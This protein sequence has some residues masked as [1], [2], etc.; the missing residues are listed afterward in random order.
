M[1]MCRNIIVLNILAI[2]ACNDQDAKAIK[3][4]SEKIDSTVMFTES[5]EISELLPDSDFFKLYKQYHDN[6]TVYITVKTRILTETILFNSIGI[7]IEKL[8]CG[9]EV[10]IL[11][12]GYLMLRN[13][14]EY[15]YL[16][17]VVNSINLWSGWI[18]KD[19]L[20]RNAIPFLEKTSESKR[21]ILPVLM[22]GFSSD[23][24][25]VIWF[26]TDG[27]DIVIAN[28]DGKIIFTVNLITI[29]PE[30]SHHEMISGRILGWSD[31]SE[32]V[33]FYCNYGG[34]LV[35]ILVSNNDHIIIEMPD[36]GIFLYDFYISNNCELDFNTGDLFFTDYEGGITRGRD[37]DEYWA[38]YKKQIFHISTYNFFTKKTVL[39]DENYGAGYQIYR[40]GNEIKYSKI[41]W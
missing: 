7:E 40:V 25:K 8:P 11:A 28:K 37:T 19:F 21:S 3:F 2:F 13:D 18:K 24:M 31:D 33:W 32:K 23:N 30:V 22:A 36:S 12:T 35:H 17:K 20:Q 4:N 34:Y 6:D 38:E 16:I 27:K 14:I 15:Y 26:N 1:K 39:L 41:D 9:T 29:D 10:V 5:L